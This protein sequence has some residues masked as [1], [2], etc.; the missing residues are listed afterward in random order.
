MEWVFGYGSLIW[1]PE[2]PYAHAKWGVLKGWHRANCRYS[3]KARGCHGCPGLM[4]GLQ[5]GGDCKGVAYAIS[6]ENEEEVFA[7]LD[8]RE[9]QGNA[10]FRQ[11]I[12]VVLTGKNA[13]S[14]KQ[15]VVQAW[16]YVDNPA[17]EG[18]V[19]E[20]EIPK[21]AQLIAQGVGQHGESYEYVEQLLLHL[22]RQGIREP[23]LEQ[24]FALATQLRQKTVVPVAYS[25]NKQGVL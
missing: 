25:K 21:I 9:G 11:K 3:F 16:A 20:M 17:H 14:T 4:V 8:R 22:Q 12:P 6:A 19:G 10:Y 2:F 18:Y 7:Y 1:K 15:T 23:K 13:Q 5:K 24:A